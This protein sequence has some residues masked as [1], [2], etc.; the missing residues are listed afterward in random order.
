MR[1]R[2]TIAWC[3]DLDLS[4]ELIADYGFVQGMDEY[5]FVD[6]LNS[7]YVDDDHELVPE[8]FEVKHFDC[9]P[10]GYPSDEYELY[11]TEWS[12]CC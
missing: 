4:E 3:V 7:E 5:D 2:Y 8:L 12:V 9:G 6:H 11:S 1:L 10:I